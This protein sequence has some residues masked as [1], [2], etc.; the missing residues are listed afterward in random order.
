MHS[1]APTSFN[2]SISYHH[3]YVWVLS[4]FSCTPIPCDCSPPGL[5]PWIFR[6]EY[7]VGCHF[8]PPEDLAGTRDG[9]IIFCDSCIA[10]VDSLPTETPG[11]LLASHILLPLSHFPWTFCYQIITLQGQSLHFIH[12]HIFGILLMIWPNW[13]LNKYLL[14]KI[15]LVKHCKCFRKDSKQV[16]LIRM[17]TEKQNNYM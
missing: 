16:N 1:H 4:H 14:K 9:T 17:I 10:V 6:Q 11:K 13:V 12:F 3:M 5:P 15:R 2:T 7:W 8:P